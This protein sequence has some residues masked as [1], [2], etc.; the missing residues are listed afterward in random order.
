[1][2]GRGASAGGGVLLGKESLFLDGIK[3]AVAP[4]IA[5]QEPPRR[6]HQSTKYPESLN[7]LDRVLRARGVIPAARTERGGDP[8]LVEAQEQH[9][10]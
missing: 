7:G 2:G 10:K 5:P 8:P 6:K 3:P 1:M 4:R 9:D